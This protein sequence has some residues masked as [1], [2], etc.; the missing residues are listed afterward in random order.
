MT[1]QWLGLCASTA[2]GAD[3]IPGQGTKIPQIS[4]CG[5]E[6]QKTTQSPRDPS[7]RDVNFLMPPLG[8]TLGSSCPSTALVKG[9]FKDCLKEGSHLV[10][11]MLFKT[12]VYCGE[13]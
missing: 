1:V 12:P 2:G 9:Q 7:L 5:Q 10:K 4:G 13:G 8:G 11:H 3:S 6:N